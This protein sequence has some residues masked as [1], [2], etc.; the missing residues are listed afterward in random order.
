MLVITLDT[1]NKARSDNS[2]LNVKIKAL[3]QHMQE[4]GIPMLDY[5]NVRKKAKMNALLDRDE[6]HGK[7][8]FMDSFQKWRKI[9]VHSR[10]KEFKFSNLVKFM[11]NN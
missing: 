9:F 11:K 8:F 5:V 4:K 2:E 10:K 3:N 7:Q 1:I 6:F